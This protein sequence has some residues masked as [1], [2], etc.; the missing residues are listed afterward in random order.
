M[1]SD[2]IN[3]PSNGL[4]YFDASSLTQDINLILRDGFT[5]FDQSVTLSAANPDGDFLIKVKGDNFI[6]PNEKISFH[7][8][9]TANFTQQNTVWDQDTAIGTIENDDGLLLLNPVTKVTFDGLL[10]DV[11]KN[12]VTQDLI[13]AAQRIVEKVGG[14][15]QFQI[16]VHLGTLKPDELASA[17]PITDEHL[18]IRGKDIAIPNVL[19]MLQDGHHTDPNGVDLPD[20]AITLD[21]NKLLQFYSGFSDRDMTS[22]LTHELLHG[23]GFG[24]RDTKTGQQ[25][26]WDLLINK[27]GKGWVY[28]GDAAKNSRGGYAL[29]QRDGGHLVNAGDLMDPS[30]NGPNDPI[31]EKDVAILHDLGYGGGVPSWWPNKV[32]AS[33]GPSA[34]Y[35]LA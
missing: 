26:V 34:D 35:F 10:D 13:A 11:I 19:W 17:R 33:L 32:A 22:I 5:V 31:T 3:H 9:Q 14:L 1:P 21:L 6:E 2:A 15:P 20:I 24:Y 23:L 4:K 12:Y 29:D 28:T 18:K 16:G 7:V 25:E 27:E 30:Y 8:V